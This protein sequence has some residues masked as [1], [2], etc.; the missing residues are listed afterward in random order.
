MKTGIMGGT[1]NPI[2]N[3]HLMLAGHVME[4]FGLD[5]IWFMPNGN[6]PHKRQESIGTSTSDRLEMVRIAIGDCPKFSIQPYEA[7]K[8]TVSYSYQTME[9]FRKSYPDRDFYFIIGA[10][11]LF[12]METWGH[13][14]R[15]LSCCT[16]IA[17]KRDSKETDQ[18]MKKQIS[19]LEG[20]YHAQ[21]LLSQ[22]PVFEVSSSE[23]REMIQRN[24]PIEGLVPEGVADYIRENHI[25]GDGNDESENQQNA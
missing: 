13:P 1:F 14:D 15:L 21:I 16:V 12:Q 2:H 11:S 4:E 9:E 25:Y 5:E 18:D 6:P 24:H 3:G 19:Y 7:E 20:K 22:S 10:D 17:A 8:K 23:I